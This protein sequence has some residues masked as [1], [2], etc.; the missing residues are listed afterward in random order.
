MSN[1]LIFLS[2]CA[3]GIVKLNLK[4]SILYRDDISEKPEKINSVARETMRKNFGYESFHL[5][6]NIA[7]AKI[8]DVDLNQ[9]FSVIRLPRK[10]RH[11]QVPS[12]RVSL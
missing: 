5:T 1:L 6:T 10:K 2:K 11:F 4:I 8:F 7:D 12:G 3:K 9:D